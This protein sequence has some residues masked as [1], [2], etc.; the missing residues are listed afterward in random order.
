ME[1][2][3]VGNFGDPDPVTS[4]GDLDLGETVDILDLD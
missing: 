4:V 3:L 1:F 2:D